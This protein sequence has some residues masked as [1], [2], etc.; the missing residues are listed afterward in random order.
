MFHNDSFKILKITNKRAHLVRL[1]VI[2]DTTILKVQLRIT[3]STNSDPLES[4]IGDEVRAKLLRLFILNKDF[5]YTVADFSKTLQKQDLVLRAALRHL[6]R[7]NIIRKKKISKPNQKSRGVSKAV[8]YGFNK[9][10]PHRDF[11]DSVVQGSMPTE[12][13]VLAGKIARVSGVRCIVISNIFM[14]KPKDHVDLIVASSEDNEAEIKILVQKTEGIIGRELRCVFL[15]ENDL[16][17]RIRINDRFIR[18]ILEEGKYTV[19]LD[20]VGLFKNTG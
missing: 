17:Y 12:K 9:R 15:T 7:D 18:A 14:E 3:M 11:L 13:D 4:I 20:R 5:V 19:H 16:L 2:T 8:G 10:Y 1:F 6:E